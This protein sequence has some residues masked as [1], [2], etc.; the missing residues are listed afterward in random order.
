MSIKNIKCPNCGGSIQIEDSLEKGFCMYCGGVIIVQDEIQKIKI[1]HTGKVE[2][3]GKVQIDDSQKM[4][5]FLCIAERAFEVG[6]FREAYTYYNKVLECDFKNT[7]AS[8][9]KILAAAYLS[10]T[11]IFELEQTMDTRIAEIYKSSNDKT[12]DI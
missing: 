6:D 12:A 11:R 3:S 4:H 10:H 1:E 2:V 8:F 5:N 9:R 7:Y